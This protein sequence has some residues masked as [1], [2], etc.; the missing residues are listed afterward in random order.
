MAASALV[1][2]VL[3]LSFFAGELS[4]LMTNMRSNLTLLVVVV[5]LFG[6]TQTG[7]FSPSHHFLRS[8]CST[9]GGNQRILTTRRDAS[10]VSSNVQVKETPSTVVTNKKK[11]G[12]SKPQQQ[13]QQEDIVIT[14]PK[15]LSTLA[16]FQFL[17]ESFRGQTHHF[18]TRLMKQHGDCFIIWNRYV[19]LTNK[20]AIRDVLETHNLEKTNE[21]KKGYRS[22]FYRRGGI[23]AAPFAQWIQQRR[24]TAPALQPKVIFTELLPKFVVSA[25][26]I[27]NL[28]EKAASTNRIVEMDQVFTAFTLDTI[29]LVL[30]G[31]DFDVGERLAK[32]NTRD[33]QFVT[34]M[35]VLTQEAIRQMT[36]PNKLLQIFAPS[37][38][39]QEAKEYVDGFLN[40]CIQERLQERRDGRANQMDM[41]NILLDAEEEGVIRRDDVKGQLLT[42]IFAGHDTTAHTLSWLL[43]EVSL[44]NELQQ[45]LYQEAKAA[46]PSR[47]DFVTNPDVLQHQLPLLDRVWKETNRKHPAAATGTL[48]KVG[49]SPI[50]VGDGLELP[51]KASVLIPPYSLHRNEEYWPNP[52]VFDPSRFTPEQ[53]AIRDQMAFQAFSGGPRNCIGSKLARAE[54]MSVLAVL[55]RRFKVECVERGEIADFC[56]LTRRPSDGIRFKFIARE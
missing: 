9:C 51:A 25:T 19:I 13:Q 55:F 38:Q 36:L 17:F 14:R 49:N 23:L 48:R 45:D 50:I 2:F 30:L 21:V 32:G 12:L 11:Y 29:G 54:A 56:S 35:N 1:C 8:A 24:M 5:C 6:A 3:V 31:R 41:M 15:P 4:P 28:L 40:D 18:L 46:L 44:N 10:N 52:E 27:L 7:A 43:Y 37:S 53:E 22:M 33:V 16:G 39:V 26:P 34:C 42:F 47:N 20:D